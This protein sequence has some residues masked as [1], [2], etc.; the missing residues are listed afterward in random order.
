MGAAWGSSLGVA[1]GLW[2]E[3]NAGSSLR[4]NAV[5]DIRASAA[6]PPRGQV[7]GYVATSRPG[8]VNR[9]SRGS[10]VHVKSKRALERLLRSTIKLPRVPEEEVW[11]TAWPR[12][13]RASLSPTR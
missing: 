11:E 8:R 10:R 3:V 4:M 7:V 9:S 6:A 12:T 5:A 13:P 1:A 2:R